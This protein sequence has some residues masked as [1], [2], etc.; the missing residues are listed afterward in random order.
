LLLHDPPRANQPVCDVRRHQEAQAD[1]DG[2][3]SNKPNRTL[4]YQHQQRASRCEDA[5]GH[6]AT[7]DSIPRFGL[8]RLTLEE[9]PN[10]F[11]FKK[12]P[13][14]FAGRYLVEQFELKLGLG[15]QDLTSLTIPEKLTDC[16]NGD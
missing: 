6:K 5:P 11:R 3:A 13:K 4:A 1:C 14:L 9:A 2:Q 12:P 8:R 7:Q 15:L 10:R 16:P